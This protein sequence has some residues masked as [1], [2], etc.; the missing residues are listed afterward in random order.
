MNRRKRSFR[1]ARLLKSGLHARVALRRAEA[2]VVPA[3][4]EFLERTPAI[5]G[6]LEEGPVLKGTVCNHIGIC[7]VTAGK[8]LN[9]V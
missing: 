8:L 6:G 4:T 3:G 5:D 7:D 2:G 9:E 1:W